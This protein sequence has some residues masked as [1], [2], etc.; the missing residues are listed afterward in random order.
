MEFIS[1]GKRC[2]VKF[3]IDKYNKKKET[4]LF[5]W[6]TTDFDSVL[7]F[8]QNHDNI[9]NILHSKYLKQCDKNPWHNEHTPRIMLT[10][11]P[12]RCEAIHDIHTKNFNINDIKKCSEKYIRRARRI[13]NFIKSKEQIVFIR[14]GDL[15]KNQINIF[16]QNVLNINPSC[17][18]TLVSIKEYSNRNFIIKSK[19][20]LQFNLY[21]QNA[22]LLHSK[23]WS[24]SYINWKNIFQKINNYN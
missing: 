19:H 8:L 24:S 1:L 3:Q 6:F 10:K 22:K 13:I 2:N 20:F 17:N 5:D 11:F 23:D 21:I 18:F 16:I 9:D 12:A 15:D 14:F 7:F 4:L